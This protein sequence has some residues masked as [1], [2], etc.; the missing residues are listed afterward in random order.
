MPSQIEILLNTFIPRDILNNQ[1]STVG[2]PSLTELDNDLF[3]TGNWYAAGSNDYGQTWNYVSPN[4]SFPE[5]FGRFCCDQTILTDYKRKL[6]IWLL[7]YSEH[8]VNSNGTIANVLRLAVKSNERIFY[9]DFIPYLVNDD[10]SNEWFDYNHASITDN[11]LYVGTNVFDNNDKFKRCVV[12]KINLNDLENGELEYSYFETTEYGSLR[13]TQGANNIM[14]FGT[15]DY[16]DAQNM[17]RIFAWSEVTDTIEES[18]VRVNFFGSN[19]YTS[20][21]PDDS[22][23]LK[24]CDRRITGAWFNNDIIGFMWTAGRDSEFDQPYVHV[25]RVNAKNMQIIDE[26]IIWNQDFA[27]AYPEVAPNDNGDV[28]ISMFMGGGTKHPS[29]I[30]G[31]W[32]N[33]SSEWVLH[34]TDQ[35]TNGP[36]DHKWGDYLSCRKAQDGV[37]WLA[38]GFTLKGG[39]SINS[40]QPRIVKFKISSN[41]QLS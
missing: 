1:T 8:V 25:V 22:N 33:E 41:D 34:I 3:L 14:Y 37:S 5:D 31:F 10:W 18:T 39:G 29:H 7:Q 11:F 16:V 2:E 17:I 4:T 28:G 19:D 21:C 30:V 40:V 23:W 27:Y 26:P 12:F 32:N 38:S 20:I 35:G 9:F 24:R 36:S 6:L 15:H 13:C